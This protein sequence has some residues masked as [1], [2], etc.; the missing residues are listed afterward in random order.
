MSLDLVKNALY[1]R[2]RQNI[3]DVVFLPE[4]DPAVDPESLGLKRSDPLLSFVDL[5]TEQVPEPPREEALTVTANGQTKR[6]PVLAYFET[7]WRLQLRQRAGKE[8]TIEQIRATSA[9]LLRDLC[10]L[11]ALDLGTDASLA[12]FFFRRLRE[13]FDPQSQAHLQEITQLVEWKLIDT[14]GTSVG[15]ANQID[16]YFN[17]QLLVQVP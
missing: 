5:T 12:V 17:G 2:I 7:T 4:H 14:T 13:D 16:V 15:F 10:Q 9:E 3:P 6:L 1:R 11:R 8:R